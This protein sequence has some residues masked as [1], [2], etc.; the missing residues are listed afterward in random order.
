MHK[1]KSPQVEDGHIRI[2]NELYEAI[3]LFKL[4]LSELNVLMM[5]VRKTYGYGKKEDDVSASQI[6]GMC[7]MSREHVTRALNALAEMGVIHKRPG[8]FGSVVGVN[9]D[10]SQWKK[11]G[12]KGSA[13]SAQVCESV[14]SAKSAQVCKKRPLGS[15]KSAQVDSAKSAHTIDNFPI[16]NQQKTLSDESVFAEAWKIYPKRV[17][18]NSRKDAL[19]AWTA[20]VKAGADPKRMIDGVKAYA[21][22]AQDE[23]VEGTRFVM[24]AS[25][26]FGS[27][28]HYDEYAGAVGSDD[29]W[30][31]RLGFGSKFEAENAG[32]SKHSAG[33]PA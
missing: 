14:T 18:G 23:G 25:R 32:H 22:F 6:G 27:G 26:F 8:R 12:E 11:V 30:W 4:R 15:A 28:E 21:K 1:S 2:A 10:Y 13:K 29:E 3:F 17:G 16:D 20:R 7:G 5:I 19:K 33:V 31:S 24:Q 9:K